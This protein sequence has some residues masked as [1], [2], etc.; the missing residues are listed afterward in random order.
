MGCQP[1]LA[2]IAPHTDGWRPS[3]TGTRDLLRRGKHRRWP[4]TSAARHLVGHS[5]APSRPLHG[6]ATTRSGPTIEVE[7]LFQSQPARARVAMGRSCACPERLPPVR[8]DHGS[9]D[10][11]SRGPAAVREAGGDRSGPFGLDRTNET[12]PNG[13]GADRLDGKDA[14]EAFWQATHARLDRRC[15]GQV[16]REFRQARRRC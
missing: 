5:K 12:R 9:L 4:A 7:P 1:A 10:T 11:E 16:V 13:Q 3:R 14:T 15:A 8:S 6:L 2:R